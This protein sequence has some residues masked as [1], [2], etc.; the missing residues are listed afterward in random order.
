MLTKEE[1][2]ERAFRAIH[3]LAPKR[4]TV[5]PR[6]PEQ[7]AVHLA[8]VYSEAPTVTLEANPPANGWTPGELELISGIEDAGARDELAAFRNTFGAPFAPAP[9]DSKFWPTSVW[10]KGTAKKV[11]AEHRKLQ[12]AKYAGLNLAQK[13]HIALRPESEQR[14][15]RKA[16]DDE[17]QKMADGWAAW[18][19]L[20]EV[21]PDIAD[22]YRTEH[23]D[24]SGDKNWMLEFASLR[25]VGGVRIPRRLSKRRDINHGT[26]PAQG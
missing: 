19:R 14:D 20:R 26:K 16:F 15:E 17:Q 22:R 13:E 5:H 18:W 25:E 9:A 6:A 11:F 21:A 3:E 23:A 10:V 24:E 1:I 12:A 8:E 4:R 7:G 2:L